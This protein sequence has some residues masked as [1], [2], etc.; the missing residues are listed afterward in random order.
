MSNVNV[1]IGADSTQFNRAMRQM[2]QELKATESE[3]NLASEQARL[4]G[5]NSEYLS[6]QVDLLTAR[7]D[8]RA[9][10]QMAQELKA[11]ESELNLASEQARLFGTNSEYLSAQVD[12]LTARLEGQNAMLASQREYIATLSAEQTELAEAQATVASSLEELNVERQQAIAE[13]GL[14]SEEV[15]ALDATI[16]ELNAEYATLGANLGRVESK[17]NSA[18]VKMNN[19]EASMLRTQASLNSVNKELATAKLDNFSES[20]GKVS[21]SSGRVASALTPVSLGLVAVGGYAGYASVKFS[22][23]LAKLQTQLHGTGYTADDFKQQILN[24]SNQTGISATEITNAM[25]MASSGGIKAG[26]AMNFITNASKLSQAGFANLTDTV[27]LLTTV[28]ANYKGSADSVNNISNILIRTQQMGKTTVGQL[29][30]EMGKCISMSKESGLSFAQVGT[31]MGMLTQ[32]EGNTAQA[33]TQFSSLL[34]QLT[35]GGT[36]ASKALKEMSGKTFPELEASGVTLGQALNML[37]QYAKKNHIP[38]SNLFTNVNAV[39]GALTLASNSGKDFANNLATMTKKGDSLNQSFNDVSHTTGYKLKQALTQL[40]NSAI[41]LGD[42]L[43]PLIVRIANGISKIALAINDVSHTTGYKLKQALTQLQNSAIKLGDSL[44]PLIVRIANGISKIALAINKLSPAQLKMIENAGLMVIG[45]TGVMKV[46]SSVTKSISLFSGGISKCIGFFLKGENEMSKFGKTLEV[47]KKGLGFASKGFSAL[48][49]VMSKYS[50]ATIVITAIVAIGVALV[51]AY[52]HVTWKKGLGFASKGFSALWGVMSKYSTATIV[53]TAIVAIGVALVEA[54]KHVTWFRNGVNT[55]WKFITN[56]FNT[57]LNFL[58]GVFKPLWTSAI[59]NLKQPLDNF[60]RACGSLW[61]E[62]KS[63]FS[64]FI[65]FLGGTFKGQFSSIFTDVKEIIKALEPVFSAIFSVIKG[66]LS[67]FISFL[68]GTFCAEFKGAFNI[69]VTVIKTFLQ[70]APVFSAIFSVIKGLLSAF[71]SFLGG[72]FCAEFKGA[73][74]IAVTVIKTFL[75]VATGVINMVKGII[76]GLASFVS[77]VFTGNWSGAWNGIVEI[78]SSVFGGIKGIASSIMNGVI[79]IIES[80]FGVIKGIV[81]SIFDAFSKVAS[82]ASSIG[83]KVA[84]ALG[85]ATVQQPNSLR[86]QQGF[87]GFASMPSKP[88]ALA[89]GGLGFASL[90]DNLNSLSNLATE[91]D[92]FGLAGVQSNDNSLDINSLVTALGQTI[93]DSIDKA[94]AKYNSNDNQVINVPVYLNGKQIA[95]ASSNQLDRING[96]RINMANR[97]RGM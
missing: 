49:G 2:A 36:K 91:I 70:V 63:V 64:S 54:Y 95:L 22:D 48:W 27:N 57:F 80:A 39:R 26:N 28:M 44:Q 46:I 74:N 55:A 37:A 20:M 85:F 66:L 47:L 72:T 33:T 30:E 1:K 88:T 9:M 79:G 21:D 86:K 24:L 41:K 42:S 6:A 38:F 29:A 96:Q 68:G 76:Q 52:K 7:L 58:K 15:E 34:T 84:G 5:T 81:G 65:S 62:I 51:E 31:A 17:L 8:N 13:Y 59:T 10:R 67:A 77:G 25:Y 56:V 78:F 19:T 89:K 53:I 18:T 60:L 50:T 90:S 11:T 94:L 12:L 3:L 43:Q 40:Q 69:A 92:G 45:F 75:Q 71:I 4:F 73:F 93:S 14:E 82:T 87:M 32:K 35:K 61:N 97:Q 83:H 23:A 16:L